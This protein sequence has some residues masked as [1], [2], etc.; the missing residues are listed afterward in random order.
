LE[1]NQVDKVAFGVADNPFFKVQADKYYP[2]AVV[3]NRQGKVLAHL[4]GERL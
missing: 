3:M 1:L 4:G 2:E